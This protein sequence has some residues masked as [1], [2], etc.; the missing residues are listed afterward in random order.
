[1]QKCVLSEHIVNV[2]KDVNWLN[3]AQDTTD[4]GVDCF[5]RCAHFAYFAYSAYST[6]SSVSQ[7]VTDMHGLGSDLGLI[8]IY[9]SPSV[10]ANHL[11]L[12]YAIMD[13]WKLAWYDVGRMCA[14]RKASGRWVRIPLS[15]STHR[16]AS[17]SASCGSFF[18]LISFYYLPKKIFCRHCVLTVFQPL[19]LCY[20][21]LWQDM[22][23]LVWIDLTYPLNSNCYCS[24]YTVTVT[25]SLD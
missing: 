14:D 15:S 22:A 12:W 24:L 19:K 17:I 2:L 21:P 11:G 16:M 23:W 10:L 13:N 7:L 1:M 20:Y 18:P 4:P 8:K 5:D 6:R 3:I 9:K 25:E